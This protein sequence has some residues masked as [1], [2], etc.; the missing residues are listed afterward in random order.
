MARH[1]AL[2]HAAFSACPPLA[3]AAVLLKVPQPLALPELIWS[4]QNEETGRQFTGVLREFVNFWR[5]NDQSTRLR[6]S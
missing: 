2:L 3:E 5:A 1:A 6:Q 4:P